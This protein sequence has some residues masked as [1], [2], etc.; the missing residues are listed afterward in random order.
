MLRPFLLSLATAAS[1]TAAVSLLHAP[2]QAA[3]PPGGADNGL[4]PTYSMTPNSSSDVYV[5]GKYNHSGI[6]VPPHYEPKAKPVFHGY[7][8]KKKTTVKHGYFDTPKPVRP[9][10]DQD[11]ADEPGRR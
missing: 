2:A 1:M 3:E 6:Y 11:D 8:D 10:T 4:P 5:Q 7:F 9:K